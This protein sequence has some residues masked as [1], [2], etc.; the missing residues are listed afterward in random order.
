[1]QNAAFLDAG[2]GAIYRTHD[3]VPEGLDAALERLESDQQFLGCN[4]TVPHKGA[5]Y[6]WLKSRGRQLLPSAVTFEA[7]NT[8]FRGPDGLWCGD[9]T[10]YEGFQLSLRKG[11]Q[12]LP[13]SFEEW[14]A[15]RDVAILGA[16]GSARSL[17]RGLSCEARFSPRSV[18]VFARTHAK[19]QGIVPDA[20]IH[21]LNDFSA[22]NRGRATLVIQTTTVGMESGEAPGLSPVPADAL[23]PG[24]VAC[25]IVYKPHET[26]FLR[27][28]ATRGAHVIPGIGMLVGQGA[29]A[30]QK[31]L[32]GAGLKKDIFHLMNTMER[33]LAEAGA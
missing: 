18:H 9:S 26:L 14:I 2:L 16:G 3:V 19:A 31:W 5:V 24:Q 8:L 27:D 21:A 12:L 13:I 11:T 17:A 33:A 32:A 28:A 4:I 25:D 30:C 1:M 29:V 22:W 15:G 23:E 10:D 7:V 20:C 6:A